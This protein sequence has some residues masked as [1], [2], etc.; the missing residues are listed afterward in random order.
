MH[1]IATQLSCMP[2][3]RLSDATYTPHDSTTHAHCY[4]FVL[5]RQQ[6]LLLD[7][8]AVP[9]KR[10]GRYAYR[11]SS[12]ACDVLCACGLQ[13]FLALILGGSVMLLLGWVSTALVVYLQRTRSA[14]AADD[15]ALP[16][17]NDTSRQGAC[18]APADSIVRKVSSKG[19]QG[20]Y[21]WT[22]GISGVAALAAPVQHSH[23]AVQPVNVPAYYPTVPRGYDDR[24]VSAL[25]S[26]PRAV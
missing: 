26:A 9:H 13:V 24:T 14:C 2:L 21:T 11:W 16:I 5:L 18:E 20:E 1:A 4:C 6:V 22:D 12:H 17:S 23:P 7:V 19:G 10:N 25:P 15:T 8:H 3:L